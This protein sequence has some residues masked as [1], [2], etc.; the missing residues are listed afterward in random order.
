[1]KKKILVARVNNTDKKDTQVKANASLDNSWMTSANCLDTVQAIPVT[2]GE[3]LPI[4]DEH[5]NLTYKKKPVDF[6]SDDP[7]E[8][9]IAQNICADCPVR[10]QCAQFALDNHTVEGVWSGADSQTLREVQGVDE[11]YQ[12][13]SYKKATI[14]IVCETKEHLQVTERR[15]SKTKI[16]CNG[17]GT[18]WY[19][20]KLLG[21]RLEN[22]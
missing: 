18:E 19:T 22:W 4:M 14:C 3:G 1:M 2:N 9:K 17:C 6:F 10:Q 16:R 20:K 11:F 15:R 7:I 21:K 13:F 5:G 12:P 8:V